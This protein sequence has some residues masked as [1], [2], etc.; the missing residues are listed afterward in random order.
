[1]SKFH[2][3]FGVRRHFEILAGASI[4][5]LA[6]SP[7][8]AQSVTVPGDHVEEVIVTGSYIRTSVKDTA[9][10]VSV[11]GR[12]EFGV[13]ALQTVDDLVKIMPSNGQSK[14][15]SD[16]VGSPHTAGTAQINLR[17]LGLASTLTLINGRRQTASP[18]PDTDGSSFVDINTIPLIMVDRLEVLQ[19]GAAALYGSD[20]VAGVANF[21]MR[22]SF[23]GMELR[24]SRQMTTNAQQFDT[25]LG[26]VGGL[27]GNRWNFVAGLEYLNRDPLGQQDRI[28]S[29]GKAMSSLGFPGAFAPAGGSPL[30]DPGCAAAGGSPVHIN[31]SDSTVGYCAMNLSPY[32]DLIAREY[33]LNS[34]A[35]ANYRLDGDITLYA[36][37]GYA[38]SRVD[39]RAS[40]SYIDLK[41]PTVPAN[42]PGNLVANGGFGIP[43]TFFGRPFGNPDAPYTHQPHI[44][45]TYRA[46]VGAKG[47]LAG[48]WTFDTSYSY[49]TQSVYIAIP[50]DVNAARFEAALNCV[51]GPNN[52]LCFNPFASSVLNPALSNSLAVIDDFMATS[53]RQYDASLHSVDA[54]F[55]G[56][57]FALPAGQVA[58]AVGGQ[59]RHEV[60]EFKSD[61][62]TQSGQL[63]FQFTGPDF[64]QG[65]SIYAGFFELDIPLLES[66]SAQAAGRYEHYSD[67]GGS[68]NPKLALRWQPLDSLVL[69]GSIGTSFRAPSLS[70]VTAISTI[71]T[72]IADPYNPS[73]VPFYTDIVTVP[74][75]SLADETAT[76]YSLGGVW[77]P[78]P[79]LSF[80][81]DYWHYKYKNM[82]VKQDAQ[83]IVN[84]DPNDPRIVRVGGPT[85][86][87]SEIHVSFVNARS[88]ETDGFDFA[89]NYQHDLGGLGVLYLNGRGTYMNK[90]MAD[91]GH[92]IENLA[93]KRNYQNFA[94]AL[95]KFKGNATASWKYDEHMISVSLNYIDSYEENL[96][97]LASPINGFKINSF[98]TVD[99]QYAVDIER[100]GANLSVGL[101]NAFDAK[102]PAVGLTNVEL[103][104]YDRQIHD[105]RGR[106][107]YLKVAKSF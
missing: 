78:L 90:Y 18:V 73:T 28:F 104:G 51:G 19:D 49:S 30:I 75:S 56:D 60:L 14:T 34:Y 40:P 82:V 6:L 97:D 23:D 50:G 58:M 77:T 95:P 62:L 10:P 67:V 61:P 80:S 89:A 12:E 85:G 71:N 105:P 4:A 13:K 47:L 33:R 43:V 94:H 86:L 57:L 96:A 83:S 84:A 92:G 99:L 64:S 46:V 26:A 31:P 74:S 107:L 66:L 29:R 24:A 32:F 91:V 9:S 8:L 76:N 22:N 20:A 42:N 45:D 17:G 21:V 48:S 3:D 53:I 25:T 63:G 88:V 37:G 16:A 106:I 65:R 68:F 52:D 39:I 38:H 55:T 102:P 11:I 81:L 2:G 98:T 70:Q 7:A 59:F 103:S 79:E 44:L 35:S 69:R 101:I 87:I 5:V 15:Y 100:W 93:G 72:A 1:M 27:S 41:F 54:V 36:E